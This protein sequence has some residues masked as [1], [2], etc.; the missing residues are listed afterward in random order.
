MFNFS[1]QRPNFSCEQFLADIEVTF[2][3]ASN[4][5]SVSVNFKTSVTY[6]LS[7]KYCFKIHRKFQRYMSWAEN[8]KEIDSVLPSSELHVALYL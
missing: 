5:L 1:F 2:I 3:P 4:I 7:Q 8:Y 6:D